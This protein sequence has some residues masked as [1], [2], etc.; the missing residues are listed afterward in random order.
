MN[1]ITALLSRAAQITTDQVTLPN[2]V[3]KE[4]FLTTQ[5]QSALQVVFIIMGA[6]AVLIITIAAL[7]YVISAG[8]PQKVGRAKD[9]IIYALIGLVVAILAF[10][11]V[12]FVLNGVFK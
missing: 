10:A 11:I 4:G 7:Q 6:I 1:T 12:S 8:D 5:F 9:T 2:K 3:D